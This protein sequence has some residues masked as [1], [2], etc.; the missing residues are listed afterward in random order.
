MTARRTWID[1]A[2]A[3]L[4]DS[5]V[6][7]LRDVPLRG[8]TYF[9]IGGPASLLLEPE[10]PEALAPVLA[11]FTAAAV[12]FEVL[13]A[14]SNLLVADEGPSFVVIASEA[15]GA[16]PR[17]QGETVRVGAGYSVPRLVKRLA[18]GGLAGLEF[19][20]G[21]PGSVG[22]CVRMNAGWHEGAFGNS[23][24]SLTAVSRQGAIEEITIAPGAFAY[25]A[26]PG[27]GDRFVVAATLRLTPDDPARIAERVR[28]FHDRRVKTQPTGS[29]NAGCIFKNPPGDHAGRLIDSAGLKSLAVGAA[30]VSDLHANFIL[31]RGGATFREVAALIDAVR[32]AVFKKTGVTLE[33]E[34]IRWT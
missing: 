5:R 12:P 22:G 10:D 24:A 23:V 29:K 11:R 33:E 25:R 14:G 31:N 26:C 15:L 27:L 3:I 17:L 34:V 18:K 8:R 28:G 32:E 9:G 21:I 19:A 13:G 7:L 30:A 2:Q 16:E 20:E 6:R 4:R 1:E